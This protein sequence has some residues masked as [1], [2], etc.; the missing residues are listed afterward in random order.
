VQLV[1]AFCERCGMEDAWCVHGRQS[2]WPELTAEQFW[3]RLIE[4]VLE[5]E[6]ER[7]GPLVTAQYGGR[8]R[9]CAVRWEPGEQI[10][11]DDDEDAWICANCAAEQGR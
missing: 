5:G 8:C 2:P 6:R 7:V 10:A 9:A 3:D 4:T 1:M 11:R